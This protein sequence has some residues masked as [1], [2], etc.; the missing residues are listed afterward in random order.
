VGVFRQAGSFGEAGLAVGG[1]GAREGPGGFA[2]LGVPGGN[3][4]AGAGAHAQKQHVSDGEL[5]GSIFSGE[6]PVFPEGGDSGDL[7]RGPEASADFGEIVVG[8][9]AGHRLQARGGKDRGAAEIGDVQQPSRRVAHQQNVHPEVVR[10]IGVEGLLLPEQ[11][12]AVPGGFAFV[13]QRDGSGLE[14]HPG[15]Q[16]VDE[17]VGLADDEVP[18]QVA[19]GELPV[20]QQASAFRDDGLFQIHAVQ[21]LHGIDGDPIENG[22]RG[23]RH[24]RGDLHRRESIA[25]TGGEGEDSWR[26]GQKMPETIVRYFPAGSNLAR[27]ASGLGQIQR[28]ETSTRKITLKTIS[29]SNPFSRYR[30]ETL[31]LRWIEPF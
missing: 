3:H 28:A 27:G 20:M 16:G 19:D 21:G 30:P 18:L 26:P 4:A 23:A 25:R 9:P 6:Q 2:G 17:R 8:E 31:P 22:I 14:V 10:Q 24:G 29:K 5:D 12:E 13:A 7:Q 15:A 1:E 11:R